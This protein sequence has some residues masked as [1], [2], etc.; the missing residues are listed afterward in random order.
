MEATCIVMA[1]KTQEGTNLKGRMELQ[2]ERYNPY[3]QPSVSLQAR[4]VSLSDSGDGAHT[5]R[6]DNTTHTDCSPFKNCDIL[7]N[8]IVSCFWRYRC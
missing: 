7:E 4:A 3:E 1:V 5:G 6:A 2:R 8:E